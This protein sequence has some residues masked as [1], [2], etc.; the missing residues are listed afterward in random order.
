MLA[1]LL[2]PIGRWLI[3][4]GVIIAALTAAYF[5]LKGVGYAQCKADWD[6]AIAE[7][8]ERGNEAR[9]DAERDV[10]SGRLRDNWNRD[11]G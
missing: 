6:A 8:I 3:G 10:D 11:G 7:G 5:Y 4:A 2:S 1:F 9:S